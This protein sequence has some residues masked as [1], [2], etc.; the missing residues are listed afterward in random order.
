MI[1]IL[2]AEDFLELQVFF[3][4]FLKMNNYDVRSASSKKEVNEVLNEFSPDLILLDIML[5]ADD[6]REICKDIKFMDENISVILLSAHAKLL[7]D[8]NEC[9]A[10]D[11]IEKPFE[12]DTLLNKIKNLLQNKKP[13][14]V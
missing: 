6:G 3:V 1:K 13:N 8:Y 12:N 10:D 9:G 14:R 2:I 4:M 11:V 5:G 7:E